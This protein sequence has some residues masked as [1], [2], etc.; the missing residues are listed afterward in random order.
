ML[1]DTL[2]A[3]FNNTDKEGRVRLNTAGTLNDLQT[4]N[5]VLESGL[6]VLLNDHDELKAV[7][8][9]EFSDVEKIWVAKIDWDKLC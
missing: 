4:K 9:V 7:G 8:T 3:D 6:E 1:S 2:F 5:I